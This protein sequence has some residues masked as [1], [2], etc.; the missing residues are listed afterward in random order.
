MNIKVSLKTLIQNEKLFTFLNE[1]IKENEL[2]EKDSKIL[3]YYA[4]TK[5]KSLLDLIKTG[6]E[7]T[8]EDTI[9]LLVNIWSEWR[10]EWIHY[11][12]VNNYKMVFHGN[13]DLLSVLKSSYISHLISKIEPLIPPETL[14]KIYEIMVS[15]Q[16]Q[17]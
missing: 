12:A 13:A 4:K 9:N 7:F 6:E 16:Y 17:A 14:Q 11:N 1:I 10:S 15:I 5:L 2:N 3:K 8:E